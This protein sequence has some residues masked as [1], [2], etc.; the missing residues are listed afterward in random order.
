MNGCFITASGT[1]TGKSLVTA[2]L[3]HQLRARGRAVC[4]LKPV[5]SG[6]AA[7]D[8]ATSD[9]GILLAALGEAVTE[10]AAACIAPWRFAA[11]L[12]PDMAAAREGRAIDFEALVGF[13]RDQAMAAERTDTVL[14]IEGVGGVMVP[15]T[16]RETVADWIAAL[17]LPA[18]LVVGSY[19]GSI[20]HALTAAEALGRRDIALAAVVVSES[21]DGAAPLDE[22]LATLARFLP[23]VP[24]LPLPRLA[25]TPTPWRTAPDLTAAVPDRA[26]ASARGA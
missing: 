11:P 24:L 9:A 20:S 2:A 23:A 25:T 8:L 14:L 10:E 26:S 5:I 22:V 18:V 17:G 4:A 16:G 6:Y 19:L 3:I 15:L 21:A 12:S 7:A 13:C 1:G